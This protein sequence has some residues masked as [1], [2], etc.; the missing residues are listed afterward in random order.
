MGE[1]LS[2]DVNNLSVP[3]GGAHGGHGPGESWGEKMQWGRGR[4]PRTDSGGHLHSGHR[5][6][7]I[8]R[9]LGD[10][11]DVL[12]LGVGG[13]AGEHDTCRCLHPPALSQASWGGAQHMSPPSHSNATTVWEDVD[14]ESVRA[15]NL[16]SV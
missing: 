11:V 2:G 1:T 6:E 13:L 7:E 3:N 14:S 5:R 15:G 16:R 10:P 8:I 12:A 4:Q 9:D